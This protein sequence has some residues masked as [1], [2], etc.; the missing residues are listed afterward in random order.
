MKSTG[1]AY[2][3]RTLLSALLLG[4]LVA[5][6]HAAQE[7]DQQEQKEVFSPFAGARQE[8]DPPAPLIGNVF[9][10]E[11]QSLNGS[12]NIVAD[13][14][15]RG[16]GQRNNYGWNRKRLS[17]GQL[18]EYSFD[19]RSTLNVPGDWN[20]QAASLMYFDYA[21]WYQRNFQA[22][23]TAGER[24]FLH[25]GA[26]NYT[27]DVYLNGEIL[28]RHNG[29]YTPFN[30]EVTGKLTA[31]ENSVVV[32]VDAHLDSSTIPTPNI[33][34]WQ[35]GGLV[36]DV[37][38][39]QVPERFIRQYQVYLA[40]HQSG[41]V[42]AWV[43]LDRAVAGEAI[44]LTMPGAGINL[45][46]VTDATGRAQFRFQAELPLWSPQQPTLHRVQISSGKDSV[47]DRIGLRT[48]RVDG[49]QILLNG[50]PIF[51]RGISMHAESVLKQ[52]IALDQADAGAMLEIIRELGAN[53]VRLA[54]YPHNEHTLRKADELG[55]MVWAEIPVY[56]GIDWENRATQE[57]AASQLRELIERDY[58]RAAVVIWSLANETPNTESRL[59]FLAELA[60]QARQLDTSGRLVTA[61]LFT[62][63][64]EHLAQITPRFLAA[65]LRHPGLDEA[66]RTR[67]TDRLQALPESASSADGLV[68]LPLDDP[69]GKL[70]DVISTNEYY[71]WYYAPAYASMLG[72]DEGHARD[73]MLEILPDF[74]FHNDYGKPIIVSE[75]GAGAKHGLHSRTADVWSEEYQARVYT[76]QTAMIASNPAIRG[77]T[78]W[79]LKDFR[80]AMR[81]L[82]GIQ[83]GFNRKG[84]I[85]ETGEKK[86]AFYILQQFYTDQA[87]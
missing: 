45:T 74:R 68:H 26:A 18:L 87:R 19:S 36:S 80:S 4:I 2:R 31:G 37:S 60:R 10:R 28:G 8:L 23:P 54:H 41:E 59:R 63:P 79:I 58:N 35:Y 82:N 66:A 55:L 16:L 25:F 81:P 61:A 84:L 50:N 22:E 13:K 21:V 64:E 75:F 39:V 30:F 70:M 53:F 62:N 67:I 38:L 65:A 5:S 33:D 32:R 29:G 76:S 51:M 52:G 42:R 56:W 77:I 9:S 7:K 78:P 11:R 71:G 15:D 20:T 40:D 57:L 69:L 27:A 46:A 6:A 17:G 83:E 1:A 44:R 73:V 72:I 85:S 43:E 34:W 12:W 3:Y 48:I 24:Q 14:L 86:Q 49:Q 47:S